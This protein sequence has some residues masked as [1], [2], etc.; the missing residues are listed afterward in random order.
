MGL[1]RIE[2]VIFCDKTFS[3]YTRILFLHELYLCF[4]KPMMLIIDHYHVCFIILQH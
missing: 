4:M 1:K 3:R 2:T